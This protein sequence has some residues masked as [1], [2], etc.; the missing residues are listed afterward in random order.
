MPESKAA[1]PSFSRFE[2]S[3]YFTRELIMEFPFQ[4]QFNRNRL[5]DVRYPSDCRLMARARH[6]SAMGQLHLAL[7][8]EII[9]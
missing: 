9:N 5:A 4:N 8:L 1:G 7:V 3:D 6:R 2:G